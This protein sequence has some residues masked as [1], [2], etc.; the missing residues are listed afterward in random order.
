MTLLN[1]ARVPTRTA[2]NG[3][4]NVT[5]ARAANVTD[6]VAMAT[7]R[8]TTAAFVFRLGPRA[9]FKPHVPFQLPLEPHSFQ[10]LICF[11]CP[12]V[13]ARTGAYTDVLDRLLAHSRSC[14]RINVHA[15]PITPQF[16]YSVISTTRTQ[17]Y[18]KIIYSRSFNGF[19]CAFPFFF[20]LLNVCFSQ[21]ILYNAYSSR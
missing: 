19:E 21:K 1:V 5:P 10:T 9:I 7:N 14:G 4:Q 6:D 20:F 15:T 18:V 12:H 2:G 8:L 16:L 13:R 3:V 11:T 17:K